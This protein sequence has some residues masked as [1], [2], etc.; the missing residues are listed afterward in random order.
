MFSFDDEFYYY[1]YDYVWLVALLHIEEHSAF[2]ERDF[3]F[4]LFGMHG[5]KGGISI[6]RVKNE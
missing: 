6:A 3:F 2:R 1:F 5:F 4:F